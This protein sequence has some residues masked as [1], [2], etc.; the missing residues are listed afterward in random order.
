MKSRQHGSALIVGLAVAAVFLV[1]LATIFGSFVSAKNYGNATEVRL[2]AKYQ[3]N[4]NVLS[5]GYQQ[6]KGVAGVTAMA[7]DDQIA[8]FKAAVT[9]RYGTEGSKAVFQAIQEANPV[10]DP[11]LYRKVQQVVESTQKEFQ[12]TQTQMLDIKRSYQTA[13]GSFWQGMW[14]GLAGYPKLD[15]NKY[16]IISSDG[17]SDAFKSGKQKAPDFGRN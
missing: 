14:L 6:L 2:E 13:L 16:R 9:G 3:D 8:I 12:A 15:L 17:A 1:L 7:R 5:S 4:E 11:Q 10:Q